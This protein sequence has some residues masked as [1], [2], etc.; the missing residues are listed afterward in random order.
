[1]IITCPKCGTRYNIDKD[2]FTKPD[3]KVRCVKCKNVFVVRVVKKDSP[4]AAAAGLQSGQSAPVRRPI[5]D[6]S[7]CVTVTVCNQKGGVSKTSTCLNLGVSLAAQGKK[8]LLVDFDV[9]ANLTNLLHHHGAK[10]FFDVMGSSDAK[11]ADYILSTDYN[12]SLLPSNS[13]MALLAKKHMQQ[14]DFEYLLAEKLIEVKPQ[15]DYIIIDTPPSGDFFTLNSLLASDLAIIPTQSEYLSLN[16]VEHIIRMIT[17][18]NEKRGHGLKYKV[19]VA[20]YNQEITAANVILN[21]L[22]SKYAGNLLDTVVTMDGAVQ[23]SHITQKPLLFYKK[24]S[25]A[26]QEYM[27]LANELL[28]LNVK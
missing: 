9:Q 2:R 7:P 19:L 25:K 14:G 8:V 18:I 11:L 13:K 17:V 10:S 22:K 1:M 20:M 6:N 27:S 16:G 15:F 21:K 24:E 23:E 3:P 5:V 4:E 26:A 12:V 28:A